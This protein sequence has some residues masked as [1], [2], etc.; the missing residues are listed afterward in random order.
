MSGI[1]VIAN[2]NSDG[3]YHSIMDTEITWNN[4]VYLTIVLDIWPLYQD[5]E[6]IMLLIITVDDCI[7]RR[8]PDP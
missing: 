3:V 8:I 2:S 4:D 1:T 5:K 7:L 6:T